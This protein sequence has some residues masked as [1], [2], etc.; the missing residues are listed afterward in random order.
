MEREGVSGLACICLKSEF[1]IPGTE[2]VCE[3]DWNGAVGH[4]LHPGPFSTKEQL[5][6]LSSVTVCLEIF[7]TLNL[8]Y[9]GDMLPLYQDWT[10]PP[11]LYWSTTENLPPGMVMI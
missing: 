3:V 1:G 2:F 8:I 5:N 6:F 9:G 7:G 4:F 11:D 10:L